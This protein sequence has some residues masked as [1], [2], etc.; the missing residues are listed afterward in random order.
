MSST[1]LIIP[2]YR[3]QREAMRLHHAHRAGPVHRTRLQLRAQQRGALQDDRSR[4]QGE[5][6]VSTIRPAQCSS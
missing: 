2:R 5:D 1:L 6:F 3:P 4:L